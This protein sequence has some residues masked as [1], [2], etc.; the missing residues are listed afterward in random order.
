MEKLFNMVLSFFK[1]MGADCTP[2]DNHIIIRNAIPSFEELYGKKAPYFIYFY[3]EDPKDLS[4]DYFF[5]GTKLFKAIIGSLDEGSSTT[6]LKINFNLDPIKE[7]EKSISLKNC[8]LKDVKQDYKNNFFSRFTFKVSLLYLN[9]REEIIKEIF[10]HCGKIINGDL[11]NYLLSEGELD[12]VDSKY[13]DNDYL[14]AKDNIRKLIQSDV[15]KISF[16]ILQ[17]QNIELKRIQEHF[18]SQKN[19][20]YNLIEKNNKKIK[21]ITIEDKTT[22]KEDKL[23]KLKKTNSD[24]IEKD[25]IKLD[26]EE[27]FALSNEKQKHALN[28][29]IKLMNTTVIYYPVYLLNLLIAD[30]NLNRNLQLKY[31]PLIGK[32]DQNRCYSCLSELKQISFC[33]SGHICCSDCLFRCGSCGNQFCQK[34]LT[35]KCNSCGS[36]I[37]DKCKT[38]CTKCNKSY[39]KQHI[40]EDKIL[41]KS[42][43]SNCIVFCSNCFEGFLE[44]NLTTSDDG[45]KVCIRCKSKILKDK[46]LGDLFK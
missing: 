45:K 38:Q 21:E 18:L 27:K 5:P 8:I 33:S 37:C 42:Y 44:E 24:I 14:I 6:L 32:M 12:Q 43:C 26:T 13:L 7:I 10:I 4:K 9:K 11:D 36:P 19:E 30:G 40:R 2:M 1:R 17:G 16:K 23:T 31:D 39:C 28:I 35:S 15:E 25:L 29:D 20:L 41:R 22:E 46:L 3:D 34:C